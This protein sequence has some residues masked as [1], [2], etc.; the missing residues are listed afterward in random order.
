MSEIYQYNDPMDYKNIRLGVPKPVQGGGYYSNLKLN[1]D[2]IYIQTPK[3]S[4]KN[5]L[6]FVLILSEKVNK[7][8]H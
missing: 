5:V 1:D 2:A 4:T 7:C 3:I 8:P 6:G